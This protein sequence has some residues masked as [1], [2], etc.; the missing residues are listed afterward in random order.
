MRWNAFGASSFAIYF[1][2]TCEKVI[3]PNECA[4][5][6]KSRVF[7]MNWIFPRRGRG[8]LLDGEG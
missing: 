1:E 6:C 2:E 3:Y 8:C 5:Y 4:K 7:T